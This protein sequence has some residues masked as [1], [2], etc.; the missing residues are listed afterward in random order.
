M[1][2]SYS[3]ALTSTRDQ[4]RLLVGDT[5]Q[6]D[7][8]LQDE[9]IAFL[10]TQAPNTKLAASRAAEAIAAKYA[11]QADQAI[12]DWHVTLSQRV[13][14]YKELAKELAASAP[15]TAYAGG[16]AQ[17]DRSSEQDSSL[18]QPAFTRGMI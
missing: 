11:R 8:L 7:P 3:I 1:T 14:H 15:I 4:V 9:E 16:I 5:M 2:W 6:K 13:Q 18:S 12:G 17:A 10:L